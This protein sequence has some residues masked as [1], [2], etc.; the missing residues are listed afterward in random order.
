[1]TCNPVR[2]GDH[3]AIVC[4]QR[5]RHA[6]CSAPGCGGPGTYLCDAPAPNRRSKTCD[7]H[8]CN[9]HRTPVG[10]GLDYCPEH[11]ARVKGGETLRRRQG[12][13]L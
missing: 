4:S 10:P 3:V 5:R 8:M 2:V 13:L 7:K 9:A 12:T 6:K 1:M 11:A